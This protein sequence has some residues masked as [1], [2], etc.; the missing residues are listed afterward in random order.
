M[1]WLIM[2]SIMAPFVGA[3][4]KWAHIEIVCDKFNITA[5][6]IEE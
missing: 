6:F 1:K 5:D 2:K 3:I 4:K